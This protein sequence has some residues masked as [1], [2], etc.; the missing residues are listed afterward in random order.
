V[1]EGWRIAIGWRIK[2]QGSVE[3]RFI[4]PKTYVISSGVIGNQTISGRILKPMTKTDQ[5]LD[6]AK[7]KG[8]VRARD[9]KEKGLPP[10]YLSRLAE[11]EKL[12][13]EGRGLYRHPEAPL[14]E[15][16]PRRVW[17]ARGKGNWSPKASPTRQELTYMS[18]ASFTEGK[19]A[20]EVE[21]VSVQEFSPAKTV[22]DCFKFRG[23]V[24][25]GVA[26][27]VLRAYVRSEA[28]PVEDLYRFAEVCRVRSIMRPYIEAT[29]H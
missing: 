17:V 4:C 15:H 19:R 8:V 16:M 1:A 20:H 25:L 11:R 5:V 21:G 24:G 27:E 9:L 22:A 6:V 14:T 18:G 7:N 23:R 26:I 10:R 28:G 13:R 2:A 29:M 12:R 3:N